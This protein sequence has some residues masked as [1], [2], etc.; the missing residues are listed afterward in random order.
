MD[1]DTSPERYL[2]DKEEVNKNLLHQLLAMNDVTRRQ[3]IH[4]EALP[5]HEAIETVSIPYAKQLSHPS[6]KVT[7]ESNSV[8]KV[9]QILCSVK[10]LTTLETLKT[11][12]PEL[13][14]AL[15][16]FLLQFKAHKL[17]V[18]AILDS[19]APGNIVSTR[20]VKKLKLAPDLDY[21]EEFSTTVSDKIKALGKLVVTAPD[22]VLCN[23]T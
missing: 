21:K 22:I 7:H 17:R 16:A 1:P 14:S 13:T 15:E 11:L 18:Q 9:A 19:G 5:S 2:P 4:T 3:A 20:L 23:N 8:K 10:V 6:R 12:K